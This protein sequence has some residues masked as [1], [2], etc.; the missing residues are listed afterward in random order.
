MQ[1]PAQLPRRTRK[2][3]TD[4][5]EA[6]PARKQPAKEE[7]AAAH[8]DPP[9]PH[10]SDQPGS[11]VQKEHDVDMETGVGS[12]AAST[13]APAEPVSAEPGQ[14]LA[15]RDAPGP[16]VS[17]P[18]LQV[19][20]PLDDV[21]SSSGPPAVKT[22]KAYSGK[23]PPPTPQGVDSGSN[24]AKPKGYLEMPRNPIPPACQPTNP[25]MP[26]FA[27]QKRNESTSSRSNP[28]PSWAPGRL[29]GPALPKNPK[30]GPGH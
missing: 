23:M 12:Q 9:F 20:E 4:E 25:P 22:P 24:L 15:P 13:P 16:E 11:V 27:N 3:K 6:R 26:A 7:A 5:M 2:R 17:A 29:S 8:V 30:V 1:P 14:G 18:P 10:A 19:K 21:Q 28:G